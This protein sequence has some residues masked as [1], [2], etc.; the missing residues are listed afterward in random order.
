MAAVIV[1]GG[2]VAGLCAALALAR[3]GSDVLVLESSPPP[4]EGPVTGAAPRWLRPAVPQAQHSHTLTSLGMRVLRERAPLVLEALMAEGAVRFDLL[5]S[6]PS[7]V[8]D[9]TP[10]ATD[11]DLVALGCRRTVLE[12]VLYRFVRALPG[13]RIRHG[14]KVAGLLTDPERGAV[15]GVT[16]V[17]GERIPGDIVVDATGRRAEG[18]GWLA[19]AGVPLGEDRTAPSGL[20][21]FSRFYRI[22]GRGPG[23]GPDADLPGPLNRGHA[24]GDIFER[25]AGVLHPG[26]RGTFAVA[27]G[28]LPGYRKL[29]RLSQ[30]PV[31][32]AVARATAGL[33]DWLADGVS[34]PIS[35]VY[36]MTSPPNALRA[37]ATRAPV[38]GLFPVGDAACVTNPLFGRG[39][40]LALDH[41]F[42]LADLLSACP[43]VDRAQAVAAA[44]LARDTF[45]PWFDHAVAADRDR[46][47]RWGGAQAAVPPPHAPSMR[48][49]ATAA[50]T[51]G[52]VWRG[53][54]RMLMGLSTPAEVF[55]DEAF[56]LRVSRAAEGGRRQAG[57]PLRTCLAPAVAAAT[58]DRP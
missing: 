31:F 56:G 42:R 3:P 15:Q 14:V 28:A 37:T 58:G 48:A 13:V 23:R 5:R 41:S 38:A 49:V 6:L 10:E 50:A 25:Y 46:I 32:T 51:D 34:E 12:L 53:L 7:G 22:S 45:E 21:G 43:V 35:P 55:G 9:R 24:A 17:G 40:S 11:G 8:T 52:H 44:R 54:T 27:L 36:A 30:A 19:A 33:G 1:A 18:R 39:M 4:P 29:G 26:D 57:P 20:A 16:T 2:S 47:A